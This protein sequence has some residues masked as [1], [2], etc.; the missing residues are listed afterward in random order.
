MS[1]G[2]EPG[3]GFTLLFEALVMMLAM[4][5]KTLAEYVG[6]HDTS[7]W[8]VIHHYVDQGRAN[9]DHSEVEEVGFDETSSKRGHNYVSLFVDLAG[10]DILFATEGKDA[11]TVTKFKE[12]LIAPWRR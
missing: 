9:A 8:R 7:L 12:N 6:E 3:S 2:P 5:V 11:S 10:P 4:P 1:P